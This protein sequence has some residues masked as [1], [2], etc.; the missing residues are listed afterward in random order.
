MKCTQE[1]ADNGRLHLIVQLTAR[2]ID[3]QLEQVIEEVRGTED[4][5]LALQGVAA[6]QFCADNTAQ[7]HVRSR[8][9]Q[10][11]VPQALAETDITPVSQLVFLTK[12]SVAKGRDFEYIISVVPTPHIDLS[13]YD[14]VAAFTEK[15]EIAESEIEEELERLVSNDIS[16]MPKAEGEGIALGDAIELEVSSTRN[17][18]EYEQLTAKKRLYQLGEEFLPPEFDENLLGLKKGESK[19]FT[20]AVKEG[21]APIEVTVVIHGIYEEVTPTP[22]DEWAQRKYPGVGGLEGLKERIH[23][24][25]LER[26][27]PEFEDARADDALKQLSRRL[28]S[29]VP[30]NVFDARF[31]EIYRN[32][33]RELQSSYGQGIEEYF[34][35]QGIDE[36]QFKEEMAL[37]V[38]NKLMQG[39]A[40]DAYARHHGLTPDETDY[41]M[42]LTSLAPGEEEQIRFEYQLNGRTYIL[43][44]AARRNVALKHLL[45][46][47]V[48]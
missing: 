12:E 35:N 29:S 15:L 32:F 22:T 18:A 36:R 14:P 46:N 23:T 37:D 24:E 20:L 41:Q 27:T 6:E 40:L 43:D 16:L 30:E 45:D 42:V 9:M 26:R 33:C 1:Q 21:G 2:E 10:L 19:Q 48:A 34:Y 4:L 47:A 28:V 25:L 3:E 11:F 7:N 38:R 44:E 8:M 5:P 39:F 13:S 31:A 17:G